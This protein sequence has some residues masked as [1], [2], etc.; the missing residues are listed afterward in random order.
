[1]WKNIVL[2]QTD[3]S[4]N[5]V[6]LTLMKKTLVDAKTTMEV[7]TKSGGQRQGPEDAKRVIDDNG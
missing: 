1:M 7:S 2:N 6:L 4:I 3:T 5:N